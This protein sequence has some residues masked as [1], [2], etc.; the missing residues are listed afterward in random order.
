MRTATW[1]LATWFGIAHS[2]L[3]MPELNFSTALRRGNSHTAGLQWQADVH[4]LD[5]NQRQLECETVDI[6]GLILGYVVAVAIALTVLA[7]MCFACKNA[8]EDGQSNL[9]VMS[10]CII[11]TI[12]L[13]LIIPFL[14]CK[15]VWSL[16]Q[17]AEAMVRARK[18]SFRSRSTNSE[19]SEVVPGALVQG[20]PLGDHEPPILVSVD[21]AGREPTQVSS[22]ADT[23]VVCLNVPADACLI[24]CA[25]T[26]V[27]VA[28][29]TRLPSPPLCPLCRIPIEKI[30]KLV[31]REEGGSAE[32]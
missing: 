13:P 27:C 21:E 11:A 18:S 7:C 6:P 2:Q 10:G 24:P 15:A 3:P 22:N 30:S 1:C 25:H 31:R 19:Q 20:H 8:L 17:H 29:A 32:V 12:A 28:C 4:R 9:E 14:V 26:N 5:G 23:C 16:L